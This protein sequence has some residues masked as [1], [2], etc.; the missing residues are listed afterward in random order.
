M[1]QQVSCRPDNQ[2]SR[3]L[4]MIVTA[5]ALSSACWA[6]TVE[7]NKG[8]VAVGFNN[9]LGVMEF[10]CNTYSGKRDGR[11]WFKPNDCYVRTPTGQKHMVPVPERIVKVNK[12]RSIAF[13]IDNWDSRN[14]KSVIDG[15]K[16]KVSML[17]E[18]PGTIRGKCTRKWR[19]LRECKIK[20]D[21]RVLLKNARLDMWLTPAAHE[22]SLSYR[23]ARVDF[24]V[25]VSIPSKLCKIIRKRC[26]NWRSKVKSELEKHV[27]TQLERILSSERTKDKV[28]QAVKGQLG[29]RLQSG[30]NITKVS[31]NTNNFVLHVTKR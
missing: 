15:D 19:K 16:V 8:A 31:A 1:K 26:G 13:N 20:I 22:G 9:A 7:I 27:T 24:D 10:H 25:D 14:I 17:M 11:S 12:R 29:S 30:W 28:A 23:N 21:R 2:L 6:E 18:S 5:T 3:I 4:L